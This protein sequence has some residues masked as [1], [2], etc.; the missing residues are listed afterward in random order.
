MSTFVYQ[1]C[2]QDYEEEEVRNLNKKIGQH[3]KTTFVWVFHFVE[4]KTKCHT[5]QLSISTFYKTAAMSV[6]N[7]IILVG[8]QNVLLL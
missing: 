4:F 6:C 8:I 5:D 7:L 1:I 2:S 3:H